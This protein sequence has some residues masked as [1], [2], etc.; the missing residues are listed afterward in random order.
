M[1]I[2]RIAAERGDHARVDAEFGEAWGILDALGAT[3][4]LSRC[5]VQYAEIL[6]KRGDLAGANQQLRLALTHIV[7]GRA[8]SA[9]RQDRSVSA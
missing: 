8:T 5:H 9:A 6:E 1:W 7:P 2:G 3:E 4:R